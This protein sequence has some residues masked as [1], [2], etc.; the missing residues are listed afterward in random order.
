MEHPHEECNDNSLGGWG[1]KEGKKK[2]GQ[3][4]YTHNH[5]HNAHRSG[6]GN[7]LRSRMLCLSL[8]DQKIAPIGHL[9]VTLMLSAYKLS[10]GF[11]CDLV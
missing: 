7:V 5:T 4:S 11:E 1:A 10:L 2:T 9:L 3:D 8:I 6:H